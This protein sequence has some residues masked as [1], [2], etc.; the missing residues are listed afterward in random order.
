MSGTD[1]EKKHTVRQGFLLTAVF[2]L[3]WTGVSLV[4]ALFPAKDISSR[5]RRSLQQFP[6]VTLLRLLDGRFEQEFE[7]YAKDQMIGRDAL[8]SLNSAVSRAS[9][10]V[11]QHGVWI[12]KDGWL[13]EDPQ[14]WD[15]REVP[16]ALSAVNRL[17]EDWGF[18]VTLAVIPEAAE[19]M[20]DK[21][22][23]AADGEA[24][25][26]RCRMS[27]SALLAE[28]LDP[29]VHVCQTEDPLMRAA[30]ETDV[31][32]HTDHHWT[33]A[34]ALAALPAI[35]EEL[36]QA[37]GTFEL[38]KVSDTFCGTLASAAG[39]YTARDEIHIP[40]PAGRPDEPVLVRIDG[41]DGVRTSVYRV[42]ELSSEDPYRVFMGGN[43]GRFTV[44][45]GHPDAGRLLVFK[46]SYFNCLL[47]M[48]LEHYSEIIVIDPRYYD[49][50]PQLLL[51]SM[52]DAHVLV[53]YSR[54]TFLTD[55]SF[56]RTVPVRPE[57]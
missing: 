45:T 22:P 20:K 25:A 9:G 28:H 3:I 34:G 51:L 47:P 24:L 21:L 36:G 49:G 1:R 50:D 13:L 56:D 52:K 12:G 46:D 31:Y 2:M 42:S 55:R 57:N 15:G 16:S 19:I 27:W 33:G 32:Y 11:L 53:C 54:A 5:E 40:V 29:A 23:W 8:V 43:Y 6:Q 35:M 37:A 4:N 18:D 39:V 7:E 41:K 14:I 44:T 48:L 38:M 30:E 26:S 10:N 17:S